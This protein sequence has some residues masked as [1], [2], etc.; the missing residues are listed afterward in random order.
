MES[1]TKI[2]L[3][4]CAPQTES[5]DTFKSLRTTSN[6]LLR[7]R[8]RIYLKIELLQL[9][10]LLDKQIGMFTDESEEERLK[11]IQLGVDLVETR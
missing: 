2:S 5:L 10:A 3:D 4:A 6:K 7:L 8:K 11:D 9:V 1:L